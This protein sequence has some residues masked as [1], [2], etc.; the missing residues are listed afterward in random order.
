MHSILTIS[1]KK[2]SDVRLIIK[3]PYITGIT[4][5][6]EG[7]NAEDCSI[8]IHNDVFTYKNWVK[9][10]CGHCFHRHCID[11]WLENH[12]TCPICI[13]DVE[14]I[15][16]LHDDGIPENIFNGCIGFIICITFVLALIF[17]FLYK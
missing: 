9:L 4:K 6:Y 13:Q 2:M 10:K 7:S 3:Q 17:Y 5:P 8:C 15:V 1:C 11:L 12:K 16:H 14:D